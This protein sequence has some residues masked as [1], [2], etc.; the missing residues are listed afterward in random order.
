MPEKLE[1]V[2]LWVI[3][4][5]IA[6]ILFLPLLVY[7]RVFYPYV[8]SKAIVFQILVEIIFVAW[9]F[10]F[11]YAK[12]RKKYRLDFKHPL[13]IALTVFIAV[14]FLASLFGLDFSRSFWGT[15]ER[16]NGLMTI[17]HFYAFFIV[18]SSVFSAKGACLTG[19]QGSA[20]GG[21]NKE[22]W[23]KFIWLSLA[24]SFFVGLYGLGQKLKFDFL[25]KISG[26]QMSATLGNSIFLAVYAM[27]NVFLAGWLISQSRKWWGKALGFLLII[28]NLWVMLSA[29]SRGV[30]LAF[31]F[32]LFLLSIFLIFTSKSKTIKAGIVTLL[33]LI[34]AGLIF[35]QIP[36]FNSQVNKMP[37][38]VRR[39]AHFTV[40]AESRL[41]A[42]L[43][44]L[45][46]FVDRPVLGWGW[47]N[48]NLIF[49]KYY[50]PHY[51]AKGVEST[52]FD[53]SHNQI[54]DIMALSG[55]LGLISYLSIFGVI[56]WLLFKKIRFQN[57]LKQKI[58]FAILGFMFL[59]Y[60]VQNL[61][62]FDTPAPLIIFYFSL[63]LLYFVTQDDNINATNNIN[64]PSTQ[65]PK[66]P[67][68]RFPLPVLILLVVIF[69]PWAVYKFNLEPFKQSQL[70]IT[71]WQTAK[72]DFKTG[73]YWF[74]EAL[75]KPCFINS[76]AR[77]YLA[78]AIAE[79]HDKIG[80][81]TTEDDLQN[82]GLGTEFAIAE[83]EKNVREHP[84][85]ARRWLYL[86]QLYG[87][88]V[89]YD[90]SYIEEAKKALNRALELSPSRQQVYFELARIYYY[91]KEY[92]EALF[93][94]E[95]AVV[96]APE[97][98][99]S[100]QKLKKMVGV[101]EKESP[102]LEELDKAKKFLEFLTK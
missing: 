27:L 84:L 69:F 101:A 52:W 86:G 3:R 64:K 20:S 32:S 49:D 2:F 37:I 53:R 102:G 30:M 45:K 77:V 25:I 83:Y 7:K 33:I 19:M 16:M 24:S 68:T 75:A 11:L 39:L 28:F 4:I 54:I 48:Y 5:G 72:V 63:A 21:K 23:E 73:L 79:G 42:W 26:S 34:L 56:F 71:A 70:G 6:V 81:E 14:L 96:L 8:F 99:E 35:I 62:V 10:L 91:E 40:S 17:F 46:G 60:F 9:L 95:Q 58:P 47:E 15:Q 44:G 100:V 36:R 61:F 90:R 50:Q 22:D 76:D 55:I 41:D 80:T 98:N 43:I 31:G 18:L 29:A 51:L 88:G 94:L 38:F 82:L 87:L 92:S 97:V 1:K 78:Q 59:A 89:K 74:K 66:Y 85:D 93:L 12:D 57:N 13:I 65:V 67:S